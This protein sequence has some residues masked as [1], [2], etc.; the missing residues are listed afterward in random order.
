[1]ID[2]LLEWYRSLGAWLSP[3]VDE[4]LAANK[5]INDQVW[6]P[7]MLILLVGTGVFLTLRMRGIQFWKF[8]LMCRETMGKIVHRGPRAEGDVTPFQAMTVAMG[9]TVGVG[10]IA[11]VATAIAAGGP[12]AVFW[13]FVSGLVGMATKFAEVVL[14]VHY[15]TR[16][17]G[18]PMVG[19]PMTYITR[20]L[21]R[22]WKPLAIVFCIFGALAGLGIGNM[23]Q[24]NAVAD[25]VQRV[26]EIS[27]VTDA[28]HLA[29]ARWVTGGFLLVAVGLV[30]I[31]GIKRIANVAM[32]CVPFMCS[33][34]MLA[35]LAVIVMYAGQI[36]S[37][38]GLILKSAFTPTAAVGG[39][40]G[41]TVMMVVRQGIARG[42]FSNEAG[43]GSAP[44][45]H[46]TAQTDHPARQGLWGIFE[47]FFDTLIMCSATALVIILTGAWSSGT[48]GAELTI[49]AFSVPFHSTTA[50]VVVTLCMILTAYDTILAW[51]FYGE[52]CCAF[53]FGHGR[54]VRMTYR[55]F[56]L[57]FILLGALGQL[58]FIWGI[59]DTLNGLMALPNLIAL[60]ALSGVVVGLTRG[61]LAGKPYTPPNASE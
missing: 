41:A 57:P 14:G 10:N 36:P 20:G 61:F 25:G 42:V 48:D 22:R 56:W 6:G 32:F 21:G 51:C 38:V 58:D 13:M 59:A 4:L 37:A 1:M 47:V 50:A 7:P 27:N 44:M 28:A 17:A 29:T 2:T 24:A 45:A 12:G 33:V 55:L 23:T 49:A 18:G 11:G 46:A 30:T 9:G 19:G 39:F 16:E 31:G 26:L 52:T 60:I 34:Y 8:G 35:A 3:M 53:I 54:V 5:Q 40:A 43:L 15:R